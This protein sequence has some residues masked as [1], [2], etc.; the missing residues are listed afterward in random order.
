MEDDDRQ[1][2]EEHEE[3]P[4]GQAGQDAVPRALQVHVVPHDAH[5]REVPHDPRREQHEREQQHRVGPAGAV[6]DREQRVEEPR[7]SGGPAGGVQRRGGGAAEGPRGGAGEEAARVVE[8]AGRA[9]PQKGLSSSETPVFGP[10]GVPLRPGTFNP[11]RSVGVRPGRSL[12][13]RSILRSS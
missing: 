4:E 2:E 11:A 3:V 5:E 10:S 9:A 7:S 6:R 12:H 8:S 1:A 13:P